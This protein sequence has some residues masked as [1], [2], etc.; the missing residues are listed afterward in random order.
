M[1]DKK[2]EK[3]RKQIDALDKKLLNILGKRFN[4]VRQIGEYK[5]IKGIPPL[6]KKRWQTILK[7]QLSKARLYNLSKNFIKKLYNLIHKNSLEIE[8]DK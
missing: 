6:D 1:K 4:I 5:K 3:W 7:S 2:L 8:G